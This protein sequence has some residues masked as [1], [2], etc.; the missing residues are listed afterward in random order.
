MK[1]LRAFLRG[2]LAVLLLA[3]NTLF[4]SL[5]LFACALVKL[6]LP[7][8]RVRIRMDPLL[9]AIAGCWIRCNSWWMGWAR[10]TAWDVSGL[11]LPRRGGWFLVNCNH[12]AWADIFVL[13]HL[14]HGRVPLLKFFLKRELLYVPVIGLAWWALDFPFMRRHGKAALRRRSARRG[15]DAA[16]ALR[17]CRK[18]ARVPTSVMSFAEGTRFSE[19]KHAEQ[20]SPYLR[21]LRPRA[22]SLAFTLQALGDRMGSIID[23][24]I[25]YG[26]RAP[27]F[28]DFLCGRA[29]R[30]AVRVR[31][32]PVPREFCAAAYASDPAFRARFQQWLTQVWREK[33]ALLQ[34]MLRD[35]AAGN[36]PA[37]AQLP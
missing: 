31:E 29:Q 24:T 37:A 10:D 27:A 19:R 16:E 9:N 20:G 5:P 15:D 14:L 28:W 26:P 3:L 7:F 18:F 4:W 25:A 36:R 32:L 22:G 21:L 35:M 33:D 17:A 2:T 12:Q 6:A 30:I 8:D 11:P 1:T 23:V 34:E 13:Q